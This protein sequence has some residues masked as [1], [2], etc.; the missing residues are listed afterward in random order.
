MG[1][2]ARTSSCQHFTE[3]GLNFEGLTFPMA[4][5]DVP[6][7]EVMNDLSIN[8]YIIEHEDKQNIIVPYYI[9]NNGGDEPTIHLL[10]VDANTDIDNNNSGGTLDKD[11]IISLSTASERYPGRKQERFLSLV[12]AVRIVRVHVLLST[13]DSEHA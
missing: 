3:P 7:F 2:V 12:P 8:V 1:N 11:G 4:L 6:K 5:C 10:M 9:S 13:V